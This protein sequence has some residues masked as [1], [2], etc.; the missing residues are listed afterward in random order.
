MTYSEAVAEQLWSSKPGRPA[1]LIVVCPRKR[2][3]LARVYDLD[4]VLHVCR[5]GFTLPLDHVETAA[6]TEHP[7]E[8]EAR[9]PA[10]LRPLVDI[11]TGRQVELARC[12]CA[13]FTF[14]RSDIEQGMAHPVMPDRRGG[15]VVFGSLAVNN[16]ARHEQ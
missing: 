15:P 11:A 4:G 9:F 3:P 12:H 2:H 6:D 1:K 8:A 7:L 14:R 13:L 5:P 16:R 10:Y